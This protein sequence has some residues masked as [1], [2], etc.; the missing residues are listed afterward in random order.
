MNRGGKTQFQHSRSSVTIVVCEGGLVGR[1][2]G[3][4]GHEVDGQTRKPAIMPQCG[5]CYD[6]VGLQVSEPTRVLEVQRGFP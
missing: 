1:E 4:E 3:I 5:R 2:N 6:G